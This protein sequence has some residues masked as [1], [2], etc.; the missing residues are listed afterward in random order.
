M[1]TLRVSS[2]V[3]SL[4]GVA[5]LGLG[6]LYAEETS[7][8]DTARSV[9]EA[10]PGKVAKLASWP[11][12]AQ[13]IGKVVPADASK[14]ALRAQRNSIE[15]IMTVIGPQWLPENPQE[16]LGAR[17]VL[18]QDAYDSLDASHVAWEKNGYHFSVGQTKTVF[19]V[20][21]T[22]RRGKISD[23]D[24][25]AMRDASHEITSMVVKDVEEVK[26]P[27]SAGEVNIA[28][29]GIKPVLMAS[30]FEAANVEPCAD[31]IVAMP[32]KL[33]AQHELDR[34]RW[35]FWWRRM[36]WWTNGRTL[37][38]FTLKTEGGAWAANYHSVLD[39]DWLTPPRSSRKSR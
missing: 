37:G 13:R 29:G 17:L 33:D 19:Y 7:Q 30:S 14:W 4:L 3:V 36:G 20:D 11:A 18:L 15:W 34:A 35:N 39:E 22:P 8:P 16:A 5:C 2:V 32:A 1:N 23:A 31:G 25:G 24:M 9:S 21:V 10:L 26:A 27:M 12:A 28:A 6:T 38:L